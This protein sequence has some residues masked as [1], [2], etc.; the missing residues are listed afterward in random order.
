MELV[1]LDKKEKKILE[2]PYLVESDTLEGKI[3]GRYRTIK[4]SDFIGKKELK[5]ILDI[6]PK[7]L[8]KPEVKDV[9]GSAKT[10]FANAVMGLIPHFFEGSRALYRLIAEN[11]SAIKLFGGGDTLQE[12]KNLCPE[13]YMSGLDDNDTYYIT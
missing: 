9:I 13:T 5:Y 10:I 4:V 8:E 1:E 7:S 2:I 11:K 3:E 6:D 12:L